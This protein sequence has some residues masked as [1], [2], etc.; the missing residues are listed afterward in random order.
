[1]DSKLKAFLEHSLEDKRKALDLM[2]SMPESEKWGI[3]HWKEGNAHGAI[4]LIEF[5]LKHYD[6]D[7]KREG[8]RGTV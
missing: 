5:I 8:S 2:S 4:T 7:A 1:M 6:N 3:D